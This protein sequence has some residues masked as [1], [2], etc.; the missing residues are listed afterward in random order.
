[1]ISLLQ[2]LSYL[3][4][5]ILFFCSFTVKDAGANCVLR[6]VQNLM[7]SFRDSRNE[8]TVLSPS[9]IISNMQSKCPNHFQ[10]GRHEDVSEAFY[11]LLDAM[12]E[13]LQF[14]TF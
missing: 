6:L 2:N 10:K 7:N 4:S 3:E 13:D 1:M 9:G 8:S 5:F 12:T 11:C 14:R